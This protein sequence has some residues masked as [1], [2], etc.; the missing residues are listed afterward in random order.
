MLQSLRDM[1]AHRVSASLM[2]VPM[3][4]QQQRRPSPLFSLLLLI[5]VLTCCCYTPVAGIKCVQCASENTEDC[6]YTPPAP[7]ECDVSSRFCIVVKETLPHNGSIVTMTRTCSP[8]DLGSKC[9]DS[10]SLAG[11]NVLVCY[12]ACGLDGCNGVPHV[13]VTPP[14]SKVSKSSASSLPQVISI[15]VSMCFLVL[16]I[17]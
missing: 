10:F 6:I 8:V 16:L 2:Q 12:E 1:E 7:K 11:A 9:H 17:H 13:V 4:Q 3:Q 14:S 15:A 5:L